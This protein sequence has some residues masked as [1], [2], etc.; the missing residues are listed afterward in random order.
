MLGT[1]ETDTVISYIFHFSAVQ[2]LAVHNAVLEQRK[3]LQ[4][5]LSP[6]AKCQAISLKSLKA[7]GENTYNSLM[8]PPGPS[9]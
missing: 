7:V 4:W 8:H 6:S 1:I 9:H 3:M 5:Q 2:I